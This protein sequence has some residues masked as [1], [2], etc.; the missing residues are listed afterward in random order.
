M[1]L[2]E[3]VPNFSEGRD[4]RIID[5]IATTIENVAG[6]YLLHKDIG[7]DANRTVFTFAGEPQDV[8]RAVFEAIYCAQNLIDMRTHQ[9][10]HPRIGACDVCPIIPI[11]N[12]TMEECKALA[13]N[14]ASSVATLGIPVYMYAEN[15]RTSQRRELSYFRH[16]E[17]EGLEL[18]MQ[19][20][21]PDYGKG[22]NPKFGAI[23]IGTRP[24]MLAYNIN[25]TTDDT[26]IAK[27]IAA[28]IRASSSLNSIFPKFE[29]IKSL[30]AIGWQMPKY[31]CAQVSTN[32]YDTSFVGM[33][34][35]YESVKFWAQ[36][37]GTNVNGSELIGLSPL[38]CMLKA[39]KFYSEFNTESEI[40]DAAIIGL[41]L[42]AVQRFEP[43]NK[44]LEFLLKKKMDIT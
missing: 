5:A 13:E 21:V 42:G 31:G 40:I 34:D 33:H 1:A 32:I 37:Y 11:S 41:G 30:K 10:A 19:E 27:S 39:G 16:G 36:Y 9:G 24:Y 14:L 7:Y 43:E 26:K 38:D 20:V 29:K 25:L 22:Y 28:R 3:C 18:H 15:A 6:V 8:I 35:V 44:I 4:N 23:V 2:I 17:Y 12:I